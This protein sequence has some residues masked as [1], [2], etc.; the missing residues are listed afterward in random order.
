MKRYI[1]RS[2][3]AWLGEYAHSARHEKYQTCQYNKSERNGRS[4][5]RKRVKVF[6]ERNGQRHP[7]G[8]K[9]ARVVHHPILQEGTYQS[10][11][12]PVIVLC[13]RDG[14]HVFCVLP[15]CG[16]HAKEL[17]L[18][19]PIALDGENRPPVLGYH[20]RWRHM[21]VR[22]I[23]AI[24]KSAVVWRPRCSVYH[25]NKCCTIQQR[26]QQRETDIPYDQ[27]VSFL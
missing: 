10:G 27:N 21:D 1:S 22:H 19:P 15:P 23:G 24:Q 18:E 7:T 17:V 16:C 26:N 5:R 25:A 13:K 20:T 3:R 2:T 12:T 6:F 4:S 8:F 9:P 11:R 14:E